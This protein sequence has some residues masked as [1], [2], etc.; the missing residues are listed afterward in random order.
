MEA[1]SSPGSLHIP[2]IAGMVFQLQLSFFSLV[3][4]A[5]PVWDPWDVVHAECSPGHLSAGRMVTWSWAVSS[6]LLQMDLVADLA[7]GNGLNIRKH[8]F[9]FT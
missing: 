7:M 2:G 8:L 9:A 3:Q 1:C 6:F 5:V 4:T